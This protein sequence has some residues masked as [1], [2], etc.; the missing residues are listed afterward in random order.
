MSDPQH[1]LRL[2]TRGSLLARTQ[3]GQVADELMRRHPGLR[4]ELVICTTTGD[5]VT[6]RP[7]ADAGGK[8][9]FTKELEEA[10]LA[11]QVDFV[12]HSYKDVPVTMPLV[13]QENLLIAAVPQRQDAR[14][15]LVTRDGSPLASLPQGAKVGT[16][17]L[18]RRCQLL[19][20]R[21]DFDVRPIRGNID[22]RLR[23]AG[24]ELDAVI[25]AAAGLNR[26]G[27][28]DAAR[29]QLVDLD[30]LLPAAGQGALAL[31]CR[32]DDPGT[33]QLLA[34]IDDPDQRACV[35]AEREIVRAL[36]GDCTSPI[37]AHATWQD[38]KIRLLAAVG[39]RGGELPILRAQAT[40]EP[41]SAVASVIGSLLEQGARQAL[42][43]SAPAGGGHG[44]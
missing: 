1:T 28:F 26:A 35:D 24:T 36:D 41:A 29:M 37:A 43:G 17:S 16:G 20:R 31:Q 33:Q 6:D 8:G 23:K 21:P 27:L 14:D 5:R 40:G 22:T 19:A 42:H 38:G 10:L 4:V 30:D 13:A 2:G 34:A 7:L 9:L 3:S 44:R 39:A 25:L 11:R 18:R 32:R 12:V 15:V